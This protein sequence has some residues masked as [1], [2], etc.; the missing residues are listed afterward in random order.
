[1]EATKGKAK[2]PFPD[3][4]RPPGTSRVRSGRKRPHAAARSR[5]TAGVLSVAT[6]LGLGAGMALR[7][8]TASTPASST[9]SAS[10]SGRTSQSTTTTSSSPSSAIPGTT[11]SGQTPDAVTSGS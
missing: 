1:M 5:M 7:A 6:F 10:K 3:T 9:A 2:P 4:P 8:A 11:T